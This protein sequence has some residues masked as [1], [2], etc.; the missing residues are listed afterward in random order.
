[1]SFIAGEGVD[2]TP[3]GLA[4]A[5][6]HGWEVQHA[7]GAP[8]LALRVELGG[9]SFAYSGNTQWTPALAEVARGADLLAVEAYTFPRPGQPARDPTKQR[10]RLRAADRGSA[11]GE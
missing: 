10:T 6:V 11:A 2:A 4:A 8:R 3:A 5:S 1:M 9:V 7:C